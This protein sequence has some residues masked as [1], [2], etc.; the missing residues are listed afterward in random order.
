MSW[1]SNILS[2]AAPVAGGLIGGPFGAAAGTALGAGVSSIGNKSKDKTSSNT[3]SSYGQ[4]L[5]QDTIGAGINYQF[6][7]AGADYSNKLAQ[8]NAQYWANYNSPVNQMQRLKEAG[9]NPN[10]VYGNGTVANTYDGAPNAPQIHGVN[11]KFMRGVEAQALKQEIA[12]K[13]LSGENI[14]KQNNLLDAQINKTNAEADWQN[15]Q[16]TIERNKNP[17]EFGKLLYNLKDTE[18]KQ[19]NEDYRKTANEADLARANYVAQ[20]VENDLKSYE[21][22]IEVDQE[23]MLDRKLFERSKLI[24]EN[25]L[26]DMRAQ[27]QQALYELDTEYT[28]AQIA[29]DYKEI[30]KMCADISLIQSLS[31]V[32]ASTVSLNKSAENLNKAKEVSENLDHLI[33]YFEA[34]FGRYGLNGNSPIHIVAKS[35]LKFVQQIK[36]QTGVGNPEYEDTQYMKEANDYFKEAFGSH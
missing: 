29:K 31:E 14:A 4:S 18:L 36:K 2:I 5:I 22:W 15:I 34:R 13:K 27:Y 32:Y 24:T 7:K 33:K 3:W 23:V 28:K 16:N 8:Q 26:L 12:N 35:W 30:D 21:K 6:N 10:L 11:T 20:T 19:K 1:F 17:E 25:N 9:L